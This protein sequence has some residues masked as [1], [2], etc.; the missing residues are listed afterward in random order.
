M[1]T[2]AG[3]HEEELAAAG[4]GVADPAPARDGSSVTFVRIGSTG[5][6]TVRVLTV[7]TG[8]VRLLAPVDDQ[9]DYGEFQASE[10]LAVWQPPR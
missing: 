3:T 5:F 8:V 1:G 7:R 10:V 9:S 2:L 6:A 4:Y